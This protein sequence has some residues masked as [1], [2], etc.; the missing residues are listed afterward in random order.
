MEESR[1]RDRSPHLLMDCGLVM[2]RGHKR[3]KTDTGC[4]ATAICDIPGPRKLPKCYQNGKPCYISRDENCRES[5]AEE[6][7]TITEVN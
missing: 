4:G 5:D 6:K 2:E 3:T 1:V 7:G